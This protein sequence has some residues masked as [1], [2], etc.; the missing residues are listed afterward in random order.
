VSD[1]ASGV[2]L[3]E[4]GKKRT[5]VLAGWRS[6]VG[7]PYSHLRVVAIRRR[8]MRSSAAALRGSSIEYCAWAF[9]VSFCL[10]PSFEPLRDLLQRRS[11]VSAVPQ[12]TAYS[13]ESVVVDHDDHGVREDRYW[14]I[15]AALER[16]D[17]RRLREEYY[18]RLAGKR[19]GF[20]S[21]R[22]E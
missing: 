1:L 18:A 7:L 4:G 8:R 14:G 9:D 15:R 19:R 12:P 5:R 21:H 11:V 20:R 2:H 6:T 16:I 17:G 3:G 13:G 10:S 22:N